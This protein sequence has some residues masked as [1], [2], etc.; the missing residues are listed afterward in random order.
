M[1]WLPIVLSCTQRPNMRAHNLHNSTTCGT[2]QF[3]LHQFHELIFNCLAI[4]H[5]ISSHVC[6][7]DAKNTNELQNLR[8][9]TWISNGAERRKNCILF[10]AITNYNSE[11]VSIN[12]CAAGDGAAPPCGSH[13]VHTISTVTVSSVWWHSSSCLLAG[14][15]VCAPCCAKRI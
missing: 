4:W 2:I 6:I 14:G 7:K 5:T 3:G 9:A 8:P 13:Q 15:F 11:L 1:R 10:V 12:L